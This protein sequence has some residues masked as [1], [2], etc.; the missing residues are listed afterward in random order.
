MNRD[1]HSGNDFRQARNAENDPAHPA[2]VEASLSKA[3]QATSIQ[4]NDM[5]AHGLPAKGVASE[6]NMNPNRLAALVKFSDGANTTNPSE[7]TADIAT[8]MADFQDESDV[9]DD[10]ATYKT[11]KHF[12][13]KPGSKAVLIGGATF[14]GILG[15][16]SVIGGFP[17]GKGRQSAVNPT[18]TN[19]PNINPDDPNA[20]LLAALALSDQQREY[21]KLNRRD[22]QKIKDA[23]AKVKD[24]ELQ[25]AKNNNTVQQASLA[26]PPRPL[27]PTV[28]TP[29]VRP[30]VYT[31]AAPVS[32]VIRPAAVAS[33]RPAFLNQPAPVSR[34]APISRPDPAAAW[35]T[36]SNAGSFGQITPPRQRSTP[37][38]GGGSSFPNSRGESGPTQ[39]PQVA[40]NPEEESPILSGTLPSPPV[41]LN[42]G[43]SARG[44]LM[45]PISWDGNNAQANSSRGQYVISLDD[46]LTASNGAVAFPA[47]TQ[48]VAKVDGF[49]QAGL[50]QLTVTSALINSDGQSREIPLPAGAIQVNGKGGRPLIADSKKVGGGGNGFLSTLGSGLLG[51]ARGAAEQFTR[52][53]ST[54]TNSTFGSTVTT[55]SGDRDPFAGAIQ[56]GSDRLLSGLEQQMKT[57]SGQPAGRIWYA[58]AGTKVEIFVSQSVKVPT[59]YASG[60]SPEEQ[61]AQISTADV[62]TPIST[63]AM[64]KVESRIDSYIASQFQ[65]PSDSE[66]TALDEAGDVAMNDGSTVQPKAYFMN[67][68]E[69]VQNHWTQS[70]A[71]EI[72]QVKQDELL[73]DEETSIVVPRHIFLDVLS[74]GQ[75]S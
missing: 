49:S 8:G 1:N 63:E 74:N 9:S 75:R 11:T 36:A 67:Q 34:T 69:L 12:H 16:A 61:G 26:Q 58:E 64:E 41:V 24:A 46:A 40:V 17:A 56:G 4:S 45:T 31:G 7:G 73:L 57:N 65:Q 2:N 14:V 15:V 62:E 47:G 71:G 50:I 19:S 32:P 6:A 35:L 23:Q 54:V 3:E 5:N 37:G 39:Q 38:S 52:P 29:V 28:A 70:S 48:L 22:R 10:P 60:E 21:D 33:S 30:P 72:D 51:A 13:Q 18:P 53:D 25:K 27:P 68:P 55:T 42:V 44:V 20:K 66:I 59:L 43:S